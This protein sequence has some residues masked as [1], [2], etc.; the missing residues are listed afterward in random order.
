MNYFHMS[1]ANYK[2]PND[3]EVP[4]NYRPMTPGEL[5]K[6]SA[7][8]ELRPMIRFF[9][10]QVED[11]LSPYMKTGES[12]VEKAFLI[13]C[14][15]DSRAFRKVLQQKI[16]AAAEHYKGDERVHFVLERLACTN[17]SAAD[18]ESE[19]EYLFSVEIRPLFFSTLLD[20]EERNGKRYPQMEGRYTVFLHI[21]Q[22][23]QFQMTR[24]MEPESVGSGYAYLMEKLLG[25]FSSGNIKP[26]LEQHYGDWETL[27]EK[28]VEKMVEHLRKT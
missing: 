26:L 9:A 24:F 11:V 14:R 13:Q 28:V 16:L 15:K 23:H 27:S 20:E 12:P 4:E 18:E 17:R 5:W 6:A 22:Q 1:A 25:V 8:P 2:N 10:D 7:D 3:F 21:D 19:G